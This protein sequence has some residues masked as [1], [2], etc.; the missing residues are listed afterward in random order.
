MS[1]SP[2]RNVCILAC[3]LE[4]LATH[5]LVELSTNVETWLADFQSSFARSNRHSLVIWSLNLVVLFLLV[6]Q[7]HVFSHAK[8]VS[9]V[10]IFALRSL[11]CSW[12]SCSRLGHDSEIFFG[13]L[14]EIEQGLVHL[15]RL[16]N[17]LLFF[18]LFFL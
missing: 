13:K 7:S 12:T 17:H 15:E 6:D 3:L 14:I 16:L 10:T 5:A 2:L 18:L 9:I 4:L 8:C 1:G 11:S